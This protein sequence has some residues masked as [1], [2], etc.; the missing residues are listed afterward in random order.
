MTQVAP[1]HSGHSSLLTMPCTWWS[2][3]VWRMTSSL[4]HAHSETRHWTWGR[5][6][7]QRRKERR[8]S[9][10]FQINLLPLLKTFVK[11]CFD[12][13]WCWD[14][15]YLVNFFVPCFL[16]T[17]CIHTSIR[18]VMLSCKNYIW[19]CPEIPVNDDFGCSWESIIIAQNYYNLT[20]LWSTEAPVGGEICLFHN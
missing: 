3:K 5:G 2:G 4:D 1:T 16:P 12:T 19:Q 10:V 14:A 15:V 11:I 9:A 17:C 20:A 13:L 18:N 7:R 8:G 6:G